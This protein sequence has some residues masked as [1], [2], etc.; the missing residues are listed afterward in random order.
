M[1]QPTLA[2]RASGGGLQP[3][4][5]ARHILRT[6]YGGLRDGHGWAARLSRSRCSVLHFARSSTPRCRFALASHTSFTTQT[7]FQQLFNSCTGTFNWLYVDGKDVAFL[8]AGLYP[9][10]DPAQQP[11]LPVWGDGRFE[12]ASDR[13]LP[14]AL[15]DHGGAVPYPD[16]I[17]PL[18]RAT[19]SKLREWQNFMPLR[20]PPGGESGKGLDRQLEQLPGGRVGLP[21]S[22]DLGPTHRV[23]ALA[24]ASTPFE[25]GF[26]HSI[27]R[28][29]ELVADAGSP[30][31]AS[32]GLA[33]ALSKSSRVDNQ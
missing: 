30:I 6:H 25:H 22:R 7:S 13:G 20:R 10:R 11:D 24:N 23:D 1:A 9:K 17:T 12:W 4:T 21:T 15:R 5:I 31:C 27:S 19:L 3:Q 28:T 16:R 2:S 14:S 29:R 18:P 32:G 8:H 33:A 26:G